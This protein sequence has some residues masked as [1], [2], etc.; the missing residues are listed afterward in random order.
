MDAGDEAELLVRCRAG[1]RA[2]LEAVAR[3]LM[4]TVRRYVRRVLR[5][6]S[7]ADDVEQE[8]MIE[9][10]RRLPAFRGEA[11]LS[12]WAYTIATRAALRGLPA[13]GEAVLAE[14]PETPEP[15]EPVTPER[16]LD[17]KRRLQ[18]VQA[19]VGRLSPEQRS[20][21][22]LF[23]L[24]G[25]SLEEIAQICEA[26]LP[27]VATRLRDARLAVMKLVAREQAELSRVAA[28][29]GGPA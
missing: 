8:V 26:P 4:P 16:H 29:T 2:A 11:R 13:R 21:W 15:H 5:Q 25:K 20:A 17:A 9:L 28:P 3:H 18:R 14:T 22:V 12:T 27:T 24:E 10:V 23:E 7:A 6:A 19:I 1:D